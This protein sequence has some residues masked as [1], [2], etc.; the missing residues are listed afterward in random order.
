[1]GRRVFAKA[2]PP[3]YNRWAMTSTLYRKYRPQVFAEVVGQDHI[4]LTLENQ[5]KTGR[6]AHAYLFCG[7]RGVGK[8]TLARLLAKAVNCERRKGGAS[9]PCGECDSCVAIRDGRSLDLLEIDAASNRRI[10]DIRE[11]REHIPYGPSSSRYKVVIVD[12]VHMLTTEAFNALLKTLEEPPAHVMFVLCTTEV[13]R[14]PETI[15]SRCQRFDFKRL[16]AQD[17]TERLQKLAK[18]EGARVDAEV[19]SQIVQLAGGSTR[20]AE[21]HLG[22]LLSLGEKHVTRDLAQLV[23]PRADVGVAIEFLE[24]VVGRQAGPAVQTLNTFVA[25]GGDLPHLYRQVMELMRK[26]LLVK[27]GGALPEY[28]SVALTSEAEAKVAALAK[29]V[30]LGR[31][32]RL[33]EVWLGVEGAWRMSEVWQLPLELAAVKLAEGEAAA[34]G[35]EDGPKAAASAKPAAQARPASAGKS[36]AL[37]LEHIVERWSEIVAKVREV[38]HSL[39]FILSVA[40][41]VKMESGTLTVGFQYKLHEERIRDPKVRSTIEEVAAGVLGAPVTLVAVVEDK[42]GQGDLLSNVLTTFGGQLVP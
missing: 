16:G 31:L 32:E 39:S 27:L 10:D 25:E 3:R 24:L 35:G 4:K 30:T 19:M 38:N 14:L 8:T 21:S 15:I 40:R 6:L 26:M 41:P 7:M 2:L 37:E 11:V 18:A 17:L 12:E 23:L 13:H 36:V 5:I 42:P 29:Q 34:G 22:K 28:A 9:E 1:M 20:D 33:L